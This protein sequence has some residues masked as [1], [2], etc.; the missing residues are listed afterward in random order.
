MLTAFPDHPSYNDHF[1]ALF[2][3]RTVNATKKDGEEGTATAIEHV[4]TDEEKKKKADILLEKAMNK[5][6][7]LSL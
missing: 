5:L 2:T 7:K 6:G 4:E 3:G 1:V